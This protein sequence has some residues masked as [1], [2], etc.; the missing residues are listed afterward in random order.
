[1]SA[2]SV[3]LFERLN[4]FAQVPAIPAFHHFAAGEA[5]P[6]HAADGDAASRG[7][8]AKAWPCVRASRRPADDDVVAISHGRFDVD[9]QVR[10]SRHERLIDALA[11]SVGP[12]QLAA[13]GMTDALG[14][15]QLVDDF[16]ALLVPEFLEPAAGN[17]DVVAAHGWRPHFWLIIL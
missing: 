14:S 8:K 7:G 2:N 12:K 6:G 3:S 4:H 17:G 10:K 9:V 13:I 15:H 5:N 1:M 16:G 11:K